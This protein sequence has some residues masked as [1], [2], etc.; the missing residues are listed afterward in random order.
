LID[1]RSTRA[2]EEAAKI[3]AASLQIDAL[4]ERRATQ[5]ERANAEA[6]WD[7]MRAESRARRYRQAALRQRADFHAEQIQRH[8]ATFNR[9]IH[10]H[11]VGLALC[12][13]ALGIKNKGDAA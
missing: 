13:E 6:D 4:V 9:L 10:K 12:E 1:E 2:R 11:R 8:T 3:A 7:R 5:N